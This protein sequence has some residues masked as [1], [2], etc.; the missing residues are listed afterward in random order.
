MLKNIPFYSQI[1]LSQNEISISISSVKDS[2]T[3]NWSDEQT[4]DAWYNELFSVILITTANGKITAV[5][6]SYL[7]PKKTDGE[8]YVST[9]MWMY[10][11][12]VMKR[13]DWRTRLHNQFQ[14]TVNP[15]TTVG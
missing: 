2:L 11:Y 15:I 1:S 9:D 3:S 5:I 14:K 4:D 13:E 8:R 7:C 6:T 12:C 10:L